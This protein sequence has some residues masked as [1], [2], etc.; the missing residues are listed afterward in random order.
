MLLALAA[1]TSNLIKALSL[2]GMIE[3]TMTV[4]VILLFTGE[5]ERHQKQPSRFGPIFGFGSIPRKRAVFIIFACATLSY[6]IQL[7]AFGIP[8]P[9]AHDEFSNLLAAETFA[10]GRLTNPTHALWEHFETFHELQRPHY[11]SM[12]PPGQGLI[13]A[14]GL[15]VFG[16]PIAGVALCGITLCALICWALQA[17]VPSQWAFVGGLIAIIKIAVLNYWTMSYWGGAVAAIGGCLVVGAAVRWVKQP[18]WHYGITIAVGILIIGNTRPYE[19]LFFCAGALVAGGTLVAK[20]HL[21]LRDLSGAAAA[22]TLLLLTGLGGM[23]YLNFRITGNPFLRPYDLNREMYAIV[24]H[25]WWQPVASIMPIYHNEQMRAFYVAWEP[26][27]GEV[28]SSAQLVGRWV[29]DGITNWQFYIGPALAVPFFWAFPMLRERR[30]R[31]IVLPL[32]AIVIPVLLVRWPISPHYVAPATCCIYGVTVQGL[33]R[34]RVWR[35]RNQLGRFLVR[36][37]LLVVI[38]TVPVRFAVELH[39]TGSISNP[40]ADGPPFFRN[41][42]TEALHRMGGHHL[43]FVKYSPGHDPGREWVFNHA[44]IDASEIVWARYLDANSNSALL[45]YFAKRKPWV[46]EP[47]TDPIF[48]KPYCAPGG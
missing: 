2:P 42:V 36:S 8:Q 16:N 43:V 12:Y 34:L 5:P 1:V 15:R 13:L 33:R 45:R 18:S 25:F 22:G 3:A 37:L 41:Q 47:D 30:M 17:I 20:Q 9:M 6:L 26:V 29:L 27:Y 32:A 28:N 14:A 23:G 4:A 7:T 39:R 44:N 38:L 24:P 35:R 48:L 21:R 11:V 19:G 10:S 31:L 46:I 40:L